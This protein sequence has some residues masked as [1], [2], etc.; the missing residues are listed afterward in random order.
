MEF[1]MQVC[2]GSYILFLSLTPE[3]RQE[4]KWHKDQIV[5]N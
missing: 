4:N 2:L 5:N 1:L 3:K